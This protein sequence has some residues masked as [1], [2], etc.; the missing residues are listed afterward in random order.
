[1]KR[2]AIVVSVAV[3]VFGAA[4]LAQTQTQPKSGSVEQELIKL[5]NGW[6][7]ALVNEDWRFLDRILADDFISTDVNGN[8]STKAVAMAA[9]TAILGGGVKPIS[10]AVADDF[11]VYV[12]GDVAVVNFRLTSKNQFKG[13]EN[14]GLERH[15]DTWIKRG[16]RWQCVASHYSRIAQK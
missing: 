3:L 14:I 2:I 6:N 12:Y 8:V 4:V 1:M 16:G 7:D 15:T 10:S 9:A 13:K 11:K 5:E